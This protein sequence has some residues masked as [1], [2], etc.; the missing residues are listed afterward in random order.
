MDNNKCDEVCDEEKYNECNYGDER[1]D[2]NQKIDIM[3]MASRVNDSYEKTYKNMVD[4]I[5]NYES[6]LRDELKEDNDKEG[7]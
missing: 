6:S 5:C 7:E 2:I 1:L 4:L 3:A